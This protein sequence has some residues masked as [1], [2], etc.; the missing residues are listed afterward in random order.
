MIV[1]YLVAII[2]SAEALI[3]K[4]NE[5]VSTLKKTLCLEYRQWSRASMALLLSSEV[6][7]GFGE[8]FE[9]YSWV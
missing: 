8:A 9:A 4:Q 1:M 5:S 6:D 2:S 7:I 3:H